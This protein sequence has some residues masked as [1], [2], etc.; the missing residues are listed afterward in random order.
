MNEFMNVAN[1]LAQENLI[2]NAGGPFGACVVKDGQIIGKGSN[3]VLSEKD[4]TAHAEIMAIRE[5]CKNINSHDLSGCEL[6]TTCYPCPMCLSAIIWSN[7]RKVYF[8]NTTDD[9]SNIGFRDEV[10]YDYI[11]NS[12]GDILELE[13]MDREE[14]IKAF[15][16]Y[17]NKNDKTTY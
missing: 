14:T 17:S 6:Y 9:A 13:S 7:I 16:E 8:G 3:H 11:K 1:E 15:E 10:I 12:N 2:T 4:P 5:A